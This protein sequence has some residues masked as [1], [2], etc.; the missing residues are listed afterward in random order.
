MSSS[1][2]SSL[3]IIYWFVI[4]LS[5]VDPAP[6]F[7]TCGLCL[8]EFTL[9][10][11]V[12]FIFHKA[13]GCSKDSATDSTRYHD[14]DEDKAKDKAVS[15]KANDEAMSSEDKDTDEATQARVSCGAIRSDKARTASVKDAVNEL[16]MVAEKDET[17][18]NC[19]KDGGGAL[20]SNKK[21]GLS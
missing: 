8:K 12:D 1:I 17:R 15:S 13:H 19:E 18:D 20:T 11:I 4:L 14:D 2:I 3:L 10:S 7:L 9:T 16:V 5:A 21:A 6:D